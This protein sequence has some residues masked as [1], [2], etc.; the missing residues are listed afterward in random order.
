MSFVADWY[1]VAIS[2]GLEPGTSA[3]TRLFGNEIVIWRDSDGAVHAWEDRCPHRGMRLSFG[4]VRGNH[5]TCLYHGWQYDSGGQCRRIPAHPDVKV[6]ATIRTTAY[7]CRE[8]LGMVWIYSEPETE[9]LPELPSA[10]PHVTPV[11]SIYVD[12]P[13][14]AVLKSLVGADLPPFPST[15]AAVR[16]AVARSGSLL[17]LSFGGDEVLA[18]VQ[19]FGEARTALHLAMSGR[20]EDWRG[21]GQKKVALWTEELRRDLEHRSVVQ[22]TPADAQGQAP[23]PH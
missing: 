4:S 22:F 7:A 23:C 8:Q 16:P 21:R 17:C 19:P 9:A 5:I 15:E 14:A 13:P 1:A 6:P 12:R 2:E 18:A 3:G 20:P 10:Y 11:R